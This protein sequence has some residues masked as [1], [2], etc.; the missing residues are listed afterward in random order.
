[1]KHLILL[2]D[3]ISPARDYEEL[4]ARMARQGI[5]VTTVD[6]SLA[7]LLPTVHKQ[8]G[9]FISLI[10]VNCLILGRLEAFASRKPVLLALADALGMS[11]GFAIALILIGSVREILGVGRSDGTLETWDVT[12]AEPALSMK[13][14]AHEEPP[15][16]PASAGAHET[17]K[18]HQVPRYRGRNCPGDSGANR[19]VTGSAN[20]YVDSAARQERPSNRF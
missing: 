9:A 10:V 20:T 16:R 12:R 1:M 15:G 3:G 6:L 4:A 8:L 5:S 11:L 13:E 19:S 18:H 17:G 14:Q 2:S 7:A